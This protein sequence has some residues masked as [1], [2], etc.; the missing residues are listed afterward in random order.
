M[1]F[2]VCVCLFYFLF[3]PWFDAIVWATGVSAL[4]SLLNCSICPWKLSSGTVINLLQLWLNQSVCIC[5]IVWVTNQL[6]YCETLIW[7][8]LLIT[9]T[10]SDS[11]WPKSNVLGKYG[12]SHRIQLLRWLSDTV[13]LASDVW[14][15]GCGFNLAVWR[16]WANCSHPCVPVTE[17]YNLVLVNRQWQSVA[18]KVS[19]WSLDILAMRYSLV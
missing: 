5:V 10:V 2:L 8:D 1:L 9:T 13:G 19:G 6:A 11:E 3:L 14:S 4:S 7:I 12:I 17:Q 15:R 16:L 18:G